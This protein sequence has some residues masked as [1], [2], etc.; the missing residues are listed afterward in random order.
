[1]IEI[2]GKGVLHIIWSYLHAPCVNI[3]LVGKLHCKNKCL[4]VD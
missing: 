1:M 2:H 4:H 3:K